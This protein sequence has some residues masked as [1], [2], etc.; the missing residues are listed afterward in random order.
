MSLEGNRS[1]DAV[2]AKNYQDVGQK[3]TQSFIHQLV[4]R[5]RG[6]PRF[7]NGQVP[8]V[9]RFEFVHHHYHHNPATSLK[10]SEDKRDDDGAPNSEEGGNGT[11]FRLLPENVGNAAHR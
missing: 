8:T 1:S 6:F 2:L 4:N 5:G 10:K 9:A 3:I 11:P 7:K